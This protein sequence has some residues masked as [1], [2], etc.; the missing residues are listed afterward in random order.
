MYSK[1]VHV[2][3]GI[4]AALFPRGFVYRTA[5]RGEDNGPSERMEGHLGYATRDAFD[6]FKDGKQGS[7]EAPCALSEPTFRSSFHRENNQLKR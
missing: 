7:L 1:V 3:Q 4:A 6:F 2:P 5:R